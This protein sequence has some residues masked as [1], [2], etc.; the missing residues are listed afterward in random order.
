[1]RTTSVHLSAERLVPPT[2]RTRLRVASALALLTVALTAVPAQ[3]APLRTWF[4]GALRSTTGGPAADGDY[5]LTFSIYDGKAAQSAAWSDGPVKIKVAGG[6]F[7]WLLGSGKALDA[8]VLAGL[9][10]PWI[11]VKVGADPELPRVALGAALWAANANV[12]TTALGVACTGCVSVAA[13]KFD[14]DVDLGGNSF[15]AKNATFSGAVQAATVTA[16]TVTAQEFVGDGSK[17]TG[18]KTPTGTCKA[19]EVV[20]GIKADGTLSC[21]AMSAVTKLPPDAIDDVSNGLISNEFVDAVSISPKDIPIPDNTGVEAVAQLKFPNLGT[22]KDFAMRLVLAN[23]DLS[24]VS[25]VVLPPDDKVTGYVLCDP[26][27]KADEKAFDKTYTPKAQPQK[28]DISK[29]ASKN[30][31]G[32]WTLKVLDTAFCVPQKPGNKDLCDVTKKLDGVVKDFTIK[33]TTVSN[34]KIQVKGNL[35]TNGGLQL[36]SVTDACTDALKG[37][38]RWDANEGTQVCN[39]VEWVAAKPRPVVWQGG[40]SVDGTS[41]WRYYC[42]DTADINTAGRY[43]SASTAKTGS[44]TSNATGKI[45]IKIAGYYKVGFSSWGISHHRYFELYK[46]GAV[47]LDGRNYNAGNTNNYLNFD[48]V[49]WL[50]KG[51]YLNLRLYAS[52]NNPSWYGTTVS[53]KSRTI[54]RRSWMRLEYLGHEWKTPKCGDGELDPGEACDDGNTKD[55][56]SCSNLCKSNV[57]TAV[58][59]AHSYGKNPTVTLGTIPGK[60][61]KQIVIKKIGMCGDS[62]QSSGANRF[63]VNGSGVSFRFAAGQSNPGSVNQW[64]G[65]TP[66]ISGSAR[67]FVYKTVSY[68]ANVGA[69][70]TIQWDYHSDWD[71]RYCQ[72]TDS[73]GNSYSDQ[74]STVRAW[75][76]YEYK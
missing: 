55:D 62:D 8:K 2:G 33:V 47:I 75:I 68:T 48:K 21:V 23:S 76:L 29:W 49:L 54:L 69:S 22:P 44:S 20:Q 1:M 72:A 5:D 30:P 34:Q 71:G 46:S 67:G 60:A 59:S 13:L 31:A 64:L 40:C 17:L 56:D 3:A 38:M 11:G 57:T 66:T 53:S 25:V 42:T 7:A 52:G 37:R 58:W 35:I 65:Y 15:K 74:A 16:A 41:S 70:L 18:L 63:F 26:C 19:G 24:K 39:G 14:G 32:L 12:A 10:D 61:G 27:G 45:T 6:Q 50:D 4:E 9:K 51:D 73:E 36:G 28:G 43:L